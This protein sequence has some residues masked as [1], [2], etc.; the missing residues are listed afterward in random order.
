MKQLSKIG[1]GL[2]VLALLVVAAQ[3]AQAACSNVRSFDL[4]GY[5]IYTPG[6][7]WAYGYGSTTGYAGGTVTPSLAGTFWHVGNSDPADGL[8]NDSGATGALGDPADGSQWVYVYPNY[9]ATLQGSWSRGGSNSVI[10]GCID[11]AYSGGPTAKCM[12]VYLEDVNPETGES[13]FALMTAAAGATAN[14]DFLASAGGAIT[15]APLPDAIIA[16]SV[17]TE[18]GVTIDL[19]PPD[20]AALEAGYFLSTEG[21]CA[22]AGAGGA[23]SL[24]RGYRICTAVKP[25]AE[26]E[27]PAPGDFVCDGDVTPLGASAQATVDTPEDSNVWVAYRLVFDAN[28]AGSSLEAQSASSASPR[29]ESGPNLAEVP[30]RRIRMRERPAQP[31]RQR[32]R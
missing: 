27:P 1:I 2:G 8:G 20:T 31:G 12:A 22:E 19:A 9:P 14:Y 17:R 5:Y 10:D 32:G 26:T 25:R 3:P 7:D 21:D 13:V 18:T 30:E 16:N 23:I 6:V 15:L 4:G 28:T 29:V 24:I 11:S